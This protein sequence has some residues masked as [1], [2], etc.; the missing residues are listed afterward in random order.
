MI[1]TNPNEPFKPLVKV[2]SG[3]EISRIML[4]IK[5][6]FA[7]SDEI[8][9]VIFDEIDTGVSGKTSQAIAS[10]LSELS[11]T[12]QILCITHQPIIAACADSHFHVSKEQTFDNVAVIVKN[13]SPSERETVIAKML[14]GSENEEARNLAKELLS[15]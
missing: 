11:K 15:K 10:K 9:T 6:V 1:I 8:G 7:S 12:H 3:G 14:A 4:A 5:T 13:L 2:A